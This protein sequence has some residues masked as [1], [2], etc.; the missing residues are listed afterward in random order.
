MNCPD[1]TYEI[2]TELAHCPHCARP[3]HFPNVRQAS[4]PEEIDAVDG[5]YQRAV[6]EVAARD[7]A[8]PARTFESAVAGSRAVIGRSIE[9]ARRLATGDDRGHAS[10]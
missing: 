3:A 5:R 9:E 8:D 10:Y 4:R 6:T 2:P 7:C 1:C